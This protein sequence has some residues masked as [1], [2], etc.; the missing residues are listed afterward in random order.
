MADLATAWSA[1]Q[2]GI[3]SA[4]QAAWPG[5][6]IDPEPPISAPEGSRVQL[7][8]R[9]ARFGFATPMADDVVWEFEI[10]ARLAAPSTGSL[11]AARIAAVEALRAALLASPVLN[12]HGAL[13]LL[14]EVTFEP[15]P[16]GSALALRV[17]GTCQGTVDR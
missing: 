7:R 11:A 16:G 14:R 8:L 3:V 15:E 10:G 1:V 4:I 5:V 17:V 2:A 6:P 9:Q 12:A 13:P